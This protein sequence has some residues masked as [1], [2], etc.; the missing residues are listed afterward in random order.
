MPEFLFAC[1]A[2]SIL[3]SAAI[4]LDRLEHGPLATAHSRCADCQEMDEND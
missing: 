2:L 1:T 3:G 4:L